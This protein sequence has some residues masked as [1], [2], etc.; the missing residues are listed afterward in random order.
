MLVEVAVPATHSREQRAMPR[1]VGVVR[2][3]RIIMVVVRPHVDPRQYVVS[4]IMVGVIV[5]KI[6]V[7]IAGAHEQVNQKRSTNVD[8]A[9]WSE[10]ISG[11]VV[12]RTAK[13]YRREESST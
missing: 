8:H 12:N 9:S 4:P 13:I 5:P 7:A 10:A 1:T 6:I 11:P 2:I 3:Q